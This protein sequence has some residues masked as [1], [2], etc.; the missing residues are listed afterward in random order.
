[1]CRKRGI[2]GVERGGKELKNIFTMKTEDKQGLL[3]YKLHIFLK[4]SH[5]PFNEVLVSLLPSETDVKVI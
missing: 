2:N 5:I 4:H 1:M 3:I